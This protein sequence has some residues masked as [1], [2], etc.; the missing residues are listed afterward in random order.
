M[1]EWNVKYEERYGF[2]F[3]ICATGKSALEML[4]ALK[5]RMQNAPEDEVGDTVAKPVLFLR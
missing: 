2:I 1:A 5:A 4:D 3:L